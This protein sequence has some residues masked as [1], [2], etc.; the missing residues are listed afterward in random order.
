MEEPVMQTKRE[1][2]FLHASKY[3]NFW[4][5]FWGSHMELPVSSNW[6]FLDEVGSAFC[7]TFRGYASSMESVWIFFFII[8]AGAVFSLL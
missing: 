7:V 6:G 2:L 8:S 5:P 4:F 1:N 3:F